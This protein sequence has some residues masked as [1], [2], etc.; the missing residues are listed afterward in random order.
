MTAQA[1]A[2]ARAGTV[3]L[4]LLTLAAGALA[5]ALPLSLGGL[6]W[7]WDALNH[8]VYLG[9]IAEHP[10]WDRD[11]LAASYQ[12]YQWPYL[13]WPVYRMALIDAP[14]AWVGAGWS[15]AQAM[16]ALPPVWCLAR[17]LRPGDDVIAVALRGAACVLAGA[18]VI[19]VNA[20]DT[21]SND[22]LAA[23]PLLW[24]FVVVTG[25]DDDRQ[26]LLAGVLAGASAALKLSNL[27][28][29][30]PLLAVW[31]WRT[32]APRLPLRRGAALAAGAIAGF[33]LLYAP[34]GWQLWQATGNPFFPM[35]AGWFGPMP[36]P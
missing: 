18:S 19:V 20:V 7:S 24:A 34:W 13:Y 22:L 11:V 2:S 26:A 30:P 27:I 14:G 6:G 23:L 9:W 10:R 16:L 33:V 15:A 35:A 4:L 28:F 21:T 1:R 36:A 5:A 29:V 8:H 3:E 32:Q 12:A 17:R 25:P 31:W